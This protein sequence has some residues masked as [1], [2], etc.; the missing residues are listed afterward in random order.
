MTV[1]DPLDVNEAIKRNSL[2][3][4]E[5]FQEVEQL[6]RVLAEQGVKRAED[7]LV[8]PFMRGPGQQM[9][10][11]RPDPRVVHLGDRAAAERLQP[12]STPG[13]DV[14]ATSRRFLT[15]ARQVATLHSEDQ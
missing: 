2:I 6:L 14:P 9:A 13:P 10:A 12:W 11:D 8:P 1:P 15:P 4:P 5:Q 7:D 3:D